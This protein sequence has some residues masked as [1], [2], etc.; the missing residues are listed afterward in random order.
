MRLTVSIA[1]VLCMML[2]LSVQSSAAET[3]L[4]LSLSLL[5]SRLEKAQQSA[6]RLQSSSI[7]QQSELAKLIGDLVSLRKDYDGS[8]LSLEQALQKAE[9]LSSYL[10]ALEISLKQS[11]QKSRDLVLERLAL[12]SDRDKHIKRARTFGFAAIVAAFLAIIGFS[13]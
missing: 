3:T 1:A 12:I 5:D 8:L 7:M 9:T 13:A 4:S 2:C 11:E 6:Q 10:A